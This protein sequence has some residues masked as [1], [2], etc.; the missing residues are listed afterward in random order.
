MTKKMFSR[1]LIEVNKLLNEIQKKKFTKQAYKLLKTLRYCTDELLG[2]F[3][4]QCK[5]C[6]IYNFRCFDCIIPKKYC[7]RIDDGLMQRLCDSLGDARDNLDNAKLYFKRIQL[8]L[9]D[10]ELEESKK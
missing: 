4:E 5:F 8:Y 10:F 3:S 6:Q 7:D 9:E 2:K 1:D